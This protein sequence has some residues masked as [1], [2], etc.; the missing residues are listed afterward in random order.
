MPEKV[1]GGGRCLKQQIEHWSGFHE[2][3]V[4]K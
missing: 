3:V 1:C 2:F 4:V